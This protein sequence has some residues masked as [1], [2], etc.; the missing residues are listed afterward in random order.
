MAEILTQPTSTSRQSEYIQKHSC[1]GSER[2]G[3]FEDHR[4]ASTWL[5]LSLSI[6]TLCL[7]G[8]S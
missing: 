5:F 4:I 1:L 6:K 3:K 2:F 7:S 8:R